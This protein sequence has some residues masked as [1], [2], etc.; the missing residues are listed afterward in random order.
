MAW[1]VPPQID[2]LCDPAT[3]S[4]I[5]HDAQHNTYWIDEPFSCTSKMSPS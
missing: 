3:K 5:V 2:K 4:P 1:E